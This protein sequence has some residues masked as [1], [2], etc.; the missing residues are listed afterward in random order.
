[1]LIKEAK[2]Q[3]AFSGEKQSVRKM[4]KKAESETFFYIFSSL[5]I[6]ASSVIEEKA[7]TDKRRD[8]WIAGFWKQKRL[9]V[10][11]ASKLVATSY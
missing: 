1:M 6:L 3:K 11:A 8:G 10:S 5:K 7:R 4:D 2:K 9:A